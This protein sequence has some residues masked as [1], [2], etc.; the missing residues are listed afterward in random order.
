MYW[1]I[2]I[3]VGGGLI[4]LTTWLIIQA[5][6]ID[7]PD[8]RSLIVELESD[9]SQRVLEVEGV[10]N[11]RDIGGYVT[12][13]NKRVKRGLIYRSG[14]LDQLTDAGWQ[15]LTE[16]FNVQLICDLRST[17]ETAQAPD[18]LRDESVRYEAL[19]LNT[20]EDRL[21]Q[22]RLLIFNRRALRDA[23]PVGYKNI[24]VDGNPRVFG[25]II[26]W[27]ANAENLPMLIHCTA[28]KDR[29]GVASALILSLLGVQ[30]EIIV[31]DYTLSNLYYENFY[32][33]GARLAKRV[34]WLGVRMDHLWPLLVAEANTMEQ[35]LNH[36]REKYGSIEAYVRTAAGVSDEDIANLRKNLLE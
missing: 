24:I 29:T 7:Y 32:D 8:A 23:V 10:A 19:P 1:L 22:I 2:G 9:L 30:D 15:K 14:K 33:V 17:D 6:R 3:L 34:A 12:L 5:K 28:G 26:Q 31:A 27:A 25:R 35:T 18:A 4:A 21:A 13:D 36:I 16:T 20:L 11:F